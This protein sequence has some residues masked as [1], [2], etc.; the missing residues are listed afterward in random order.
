LYGIFA[1][2]ADRKA[3]TV[4]DPGRGMSFAATGDLCPAE[5]GKS[6]AAAI[7]SRLRVRN[8]MIRQDHLRK[9]LPGNFIRGFYERSTPHLTQIRHTER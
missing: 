9:N 6:C 7:R 5:M 1:D 3:A 2:P 4:G 8:V